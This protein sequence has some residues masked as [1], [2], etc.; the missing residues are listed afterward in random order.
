M[1]WYSLSLN[2]H[3]LSHNNMPTGRQ[4]PAIMFLRLV[5]NGRVCAS[6]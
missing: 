6:V 1:S 3:I 5:L 2:R 4:I